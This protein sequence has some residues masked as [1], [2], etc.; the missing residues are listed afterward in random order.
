MNKT[1]QS[2]KLSLLNT[3]LV[4]LDEKWNYD[5]V[6]SPFSRLYYV[7]E[8]SAVV[9]HNDREFNLKPG[10]MYL[11][12][13]YT[14]SRYKCDKYQKQ[15]YVSFLEELSSGLSIYELRDF[16][17]E[18]KA[19]EIDLYYFKRML[20]INPNRYLINDDPEIYDNRD[21]LLDFK[22]KNELLTSSEYLETKG[23][24]T[25]L[26]SRF[27]KDGVKK[28]TVEEIKT[29]GLR[30]VLKYINENL[31]HHI[32]VKGLAEHSNLSTDYFSRVFVQKY[33]MRPVKYI[34][35]KR[36]ER[37]QLLLLTTDYTIKQIA[38]KVG[39]DNIS[40]F[41]KIFKTVSGVTPGA[42]RK[43]DINI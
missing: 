21:Y 10:Y 2:I 22:A 3:N 38:H 12:P 29:V 7:K 4:E 20:K 42:Y 1:L 27:I 33:K 15:Y 14:Y 43:K 8:G 30:G 32:T 35:S 11:I 24:L 28:Q 36:I 34:Q 39:L 25:T 13:S 31:Q 26:F 5:N 37:A 40:N 6:V 16:I 41:S 18:I 9:A 23:I 17:Y 19:T